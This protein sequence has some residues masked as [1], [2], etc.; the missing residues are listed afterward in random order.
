MFSLDVSLKIYKRKIVVVP[1]V[2]KRF[3]GNWSSWT[4][5]SFGSAH[6]I[7][8]LTSSQLQYEALEAEAEAATE[9]VVD[10]CCRSYTC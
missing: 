4:K 5:R 2:T 7:T 3:F 6:L 1:D 9:E 8:V 10:D